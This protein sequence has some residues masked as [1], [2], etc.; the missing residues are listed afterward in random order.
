VIA[1]DNRLPTSTTG[2]KLRLINAM[3]PTGM[4]A[5][6]LSMTL[7]YSPV[8]ASVAPGTSSGFQALPSTTT[9]ILEVTSALQ[10]ATMYSPTGTPS[11]VNP[12]LS[13]SSLTLKAQGVYTVWMFGDTTGWTG[14]LRQER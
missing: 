11:T 12:A 8:A 5:Y 13:T 4:G 2:V 6:P 7:D 14:L 1:D 3:N 10:P 9:S